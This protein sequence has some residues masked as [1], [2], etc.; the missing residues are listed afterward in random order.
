MNTEENAI[1]SDAQAY[2]KMDPVIAAS[3]LARG[4]PAEIEDMLSQL[5]AATALKIASHLASDTNSQDAPL[6]HSQPPI[7]LTLYKA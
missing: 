2:T 7:Q 5:P 4:T 1:S 3:L 6:T